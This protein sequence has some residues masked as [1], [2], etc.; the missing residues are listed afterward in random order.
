MGNSK[1]NKMQRRMISRGMLVL[2]MFLLSATTVYAHRMM[3][4][5]VDDKAIWVG[6]EDGTTIANINVEVL[7][8]QGEVL[9]A[10]TAD[11]E[12]YYSFENISDAHSITADDGMGHRVTWV[13]GE[14]AAVME[15]WTRYL[16]IAGIVLIFIL[17]ALVFWQ[18][19]RRF[20]K[21]ERT[22]KS[23]MDSKKERSS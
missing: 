11:E 10:E 18:R 19:T 16:R 7:D 4:D 17:V 5:P 8:E 2:L 15:G 20:N 12:G 1:N 21:A 9:A 6:Y 22:S 3:I 14:P 23:L 13:V